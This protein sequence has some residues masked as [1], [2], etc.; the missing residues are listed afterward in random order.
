MSTDTCL[1]C[2]QSTTNKVC[3]ISR[4]PVISSM[5]LVHVVTG[6]TDDVLQSLIVQ[7]TNTATTCVVLER[8]DNDD[9]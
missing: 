7:T 9:E 1:L 3:I 6:P 2:P 4:C 8:H 5:T